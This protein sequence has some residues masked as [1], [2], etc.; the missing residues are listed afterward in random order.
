MSA[1]KGKD[2]LLK[3]DDQ[4]TFVTVAGLRTRNITFNAATIDVTSQDSVGQWRELLSGGG[5]K[6]AQIAGTGVFKDAASDARMREVFFNGE[7]PP[8]EIIIPDFGSITGPFQIAALAFKGDHDGE[9]TFEITLQSAGPLE[10][11]PL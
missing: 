3:I 6:N 9:M 4:G 1:Q 5:I 2:L 11:V 7:V 8:L 10:F